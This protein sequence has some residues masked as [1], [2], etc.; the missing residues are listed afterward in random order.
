MTTV[1]ETPQAHLLPDPEG[2]RRYGNVD[3][4]V[5]VAIGGRVRQ[6]PIAVPTFL[7]TFMRDVAK[8]DR[9]TDVTLALDRMG[10]RFVFS[11]LA[12]DDLY[13]LW[14]Y[15]YKGLPDCFRNEISVGA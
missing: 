13:D 10:D 3:N 2:P 4:L 5:D 7:F 8:I 11:L 14:D 6:V 9:Q 1:F 12:G 15:S